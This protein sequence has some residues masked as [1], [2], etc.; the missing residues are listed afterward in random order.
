[1]RWT[2][3]SVV[4]VVFLEPSGSLKS[5]CPCFRLSVCHKLGFGPLSQW[6]LDEMSVKTQ[7]TLLLS[8]RSNVT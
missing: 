1:M 8:A 7:R 4:S 2:F 5:V 3:L 6:S